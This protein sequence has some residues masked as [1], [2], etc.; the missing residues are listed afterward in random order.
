MPHDAGPGRAVMAPA[1]PAG[2]LLAPMT[3]AGPAYSG[4]SKQHGWQHQQP[5][6]YPQQ[7][8]QHHQQPPA[9]PAPAPQQPPPAGAAC[10]AAGSQQPPGFSPLQHAAPAPAA[11]S[12]SPEAPAAA[13]AAA[14]VSQ[15]SLCGCACRPGTASLPSQAEHSG[16]RGGAAPG[17]AGTAAAGTGAA[18]GGWQGAAGEEYPGASDLIPAVRPAPYYSTYGGSGGAGTAC[19]GLGVNPVSHWGEVIAPLGVHHCMPSHMASALSGSA[20]TRLPACSAPAGHMASTLPAVGSMA[21]PQGHAMPGSPAPSDST[22][23]RGSL[24]VPLLPFYPGS[25]VTDT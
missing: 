16:R 6:Q 13:A 12:F 18:G 14:A 20:F 9:S 17:M 4:P 22:A 23:A 25:V 10:H 2:V 5:Q 15:C 1:P 21:P 11:G 19:R 8:P 24:S 7:Q 3:H